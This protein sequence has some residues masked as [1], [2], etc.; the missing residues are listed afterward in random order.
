MFGA[1][2]AVDGDQRQIQRCGDV[3]QAGV[4][5]HCG[6]GQRQ[7]VN[8]VA[9]LGAPGQVMHMRPLAGDVGGGCMVLLCAEY[10]YLVPALRQFVGECGVMR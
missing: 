8:R 6:V 4:V 1:G 3:H 7:Q 9:K 5:G 2:R 10:P